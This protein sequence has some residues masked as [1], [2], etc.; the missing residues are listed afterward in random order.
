MNIFLA[1][2]KLWFK[3]KW[4]D[5]EYF[6]GSIKDS[7][8]LFGVWG[9]IKHEVRGFW[10]R[11]IG[12]YIKKIRKILAWLPVLWEDE[13]WDHDYI[14]RV[15]KY[16]LIRT[17]EEIKNGMG[18]E[19]QWRNPRVA[20]ITEAIDSIDLLLKG[21]FAEAEFE[22]HYEK[23]GHIKMDI[24]PSSG[25]GAFADIYN[26]KCKDSPELR[27]ESSKEAM[28]IYDLEEK[29]TIEAYNKTFSFIAANIRKWWD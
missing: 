29:R 10:W 20:E 15:L 25:R 1:N 7:F 9:G 24:G 3:D 22:A 6:F 18:D 8:E 12:R 17:R 5:I 4:E 21:E 16:K 14:L 26:E 13:D 23:F 2:V 11:W 19:D 27:E 28:E